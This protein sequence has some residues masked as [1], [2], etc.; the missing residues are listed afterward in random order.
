MTLDSLEDDNSENGK[1]D[2]ERLQLKNFV[3]SA[4]QFS[5]QEF[6]QAQHSTAQ[7]S[8]VVPHPDSTPPLI[9][10]PSSPSSPHR[11]GSAESRSYVLRSIRPRRISTR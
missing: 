4:C 3:G 1:V 6:H 10:Q 7:H 2:V 5:S 8:V 9:L 11:E